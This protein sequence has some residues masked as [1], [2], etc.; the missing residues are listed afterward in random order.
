MLKSKNKDAILQGLALVD[1][2]WAMDVEFY[3][4]A[5]TPHEGIPDPRLHIEIKGKDAEKMFSCLG[6]DKLVSN[7]KMNEYRQTGIYISKFI[8][9]GARGHFFAKHF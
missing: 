4:H 1:A 8:P 6:L 5:G 2:M 9:T 7:T 3:A